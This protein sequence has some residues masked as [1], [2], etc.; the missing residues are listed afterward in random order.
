MERAAR[1]V[2]GRPRTGGGSA[3]ERA[4]EVRCVIG[5][6]GRHC[7]ALALLLY[8]DAVANARGGGPCATRG[9]GHVQ[10]AQDREPQDV[11]K[12]AHADLPWNYSHFATRGSTAG[13][14][15]A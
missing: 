6:G 3:I 15:V 12:R 4:L 11:Q 7:Q 2:Y 1:Q 13:A 8:V 5:P 9:Q 14:E 10:G